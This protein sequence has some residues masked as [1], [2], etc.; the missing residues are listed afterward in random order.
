LTYTLKSDASPY[1]PAHV[2]PTPKGLTAT[3]GVGRVWLRWMPSPTAN[4]YKVLRATQSGGP[5][6]TIASYTG[7]FPVDEDTDVINGTTYYYAVAA[8]NQTGSSGSSPQATATPMS[9]GELPSTWTLTDIGSCSRPGDASYADVSGHTF[10]VSGTGQGIGG[11]ADGLCF[12]AT[13]V[14]GDCVFTARRAEAN[15]GGGGQ[16][17]MG[18]MIRESLDPGAK[19]LAMVSGDVGA[20]EARFGTRS[21]DEAPMR[22]QN[23]DAYT[24]PGPPMWFR[25]ARSGDTFTAYQS[26]D[27]TT[28]FAVGSPTNVP[29]NAAYYVGFAISSN[30][31]KADTADFDYVTI[32]NGAPTH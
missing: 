6:Q 30:G 32:E 16:Q 3:A 7:T 8:R 12:V 1:P 23:G 13:K 26:I 20:R 17:K 15:F 24:P 11:R 25:I 9:A 22:W 27:G 5:F 21:S 28:W 4:G 31:A 2:P 14:T 19:A 18:I 10:L 29:L